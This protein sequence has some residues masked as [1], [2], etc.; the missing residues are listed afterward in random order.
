MTWNPEQ[1]ATMQAF[2]VDPAK[3]ERVQEVMGWLGYIGDESSLIDRLW[4]RIIGS[5][6][7]IRTDPII[8]WSRRHQVALK[9]LA[10]IVE[11]H[12]DPFDRTPDRVTPDRLELVYETLIDDL[13]EDTTHA[14]SLVDAASYAAMLPPRTHP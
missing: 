4:A 5:Y 1:L 9:P 13:W 2:G 10:L 7:C 6:T 14:L 8:A 11:A 3:Q 12:A